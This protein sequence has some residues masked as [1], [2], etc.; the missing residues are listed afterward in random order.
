MSIITPDLKDVLAHCYN[1]TLMS[2]KVLFPD[3]FTLPFSPLHKIIEELID[4][5]SCQKVAIAA[6]RGFGK[7]S[8]VNLA[9]PGK[10]IL[11][12]SKKYI[13]PISNTATQATLQSE[14]LKRELLTNAMI[15]KLFGPIKGTDWTKDMWVTSSGVAVMPRGAGQQV[16]GILYNNDRPDLIICDDLEDSEAVRSEDQ[17]KKLKEWFFADV[18]GSIDKSKRDWKVIVI[19]TILHEDSLLENLLNDKEWKTIRLS[20]C[21]DDYRSSWPEQISDEGVKALVQQ[22]REQGLLDTFAREYRN[23]PVS[24]EDATFKQEYFRYYEE[25]D[26]PKRSDM[27]T[28]VIVDPAKTVKIQSADTAVVGV[29]V[30]LQ[31]HA[32]YVRDVVAAKMHPDQIYQAAFDMADRIG[33]KVIGIEVTSLNEFITYPIRNEMFARKKFYEIIDL[34]PRAKKEERVAFLGPFYRMGYMYHKRGT[35]DQLEEQLIMFPRAKR[36]DIMDALAYFIEMLE[37]GERYFFP[38]GKD[39][40]VATTVD[41]L[42]NAQEA[43][44]EPDEDEYAELERDYEPAIADFRIM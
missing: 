3:R 1:S 40:G 11:F 37:I 9:L 17:R 10:K 30:D 14:N 2:A 16:R 42:K 19:G 29:S 18:L 21:D 24:K 28:F 26:L 27:E 8:L 6:P 41:G 35:C 25:K 44:E 15:A 39:E 34:S 20:I 7:T 12:R 43:G 32:V 33:T 13:V 4:D 23:L 38:K 36:W 5:D 31:H 22:Y